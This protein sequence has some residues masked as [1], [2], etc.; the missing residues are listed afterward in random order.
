MQTD[1]I[2][3]QK[4]LADGA[5]HTFLKCRAPFVR[6]QFGAAGGGPPPAPPGF[7]APSRNRRVG[8][9]HGQAPALAQAGVILSPM[10]CPAS[11]P[12]NVVAAI[13]IHLENGTAGDPESWEGDQPCTYRLLPVL[14]RQPGPCNKVGGGTLLGAITGCLDQ[15]PPSVK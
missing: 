13:G 14:P 3:S 6:A 10:H 9:P 5:G 2:R 4:P 1:Q 7:G 8:Q 12:R 11:L 15:G